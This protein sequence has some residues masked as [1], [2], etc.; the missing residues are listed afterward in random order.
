MKPHI[1]ASH[2]CEA[3]KQNRDESKLNQVDVLGQVAKVILF[4]D[5]EAIPPSCTS[6][7]SI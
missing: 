1:Q 7:R 6:T 3:V 5:V 2:A 4:K